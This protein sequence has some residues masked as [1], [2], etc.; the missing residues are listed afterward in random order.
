MNSPE[1]K[2]FPQ[3]LGMGLVLYNAQKMVAEGKKDEQMGSYVNMLSIKD[4]IELQIDIVS[5]C[6][7]ILNHYSISEPIKETQENAE[8][9]MGFTRNDAKAFDIFNK[10]LEKNSLSLIN[11][12]ANLAPQ[13][14]IYWMELVDIYKKQGK[15]AK[16]VEIVKKLQEMEKEQRNN[17]ATFNKITNS[18]NSMVE[19]W[20]QNKVLFQFTHD[21]DFITQMITFTSELGKWL[22]EGKCLLS[23]K[24]LTTGLQDCQICLEWISLL[25]SIAYYKIKYNFSEEN[26][27]S[28]LKD[29][30]E[31]FLGF[32]PEQL[33]PIQ[34]PNFLSLAH[35]K[36]KWMTIMGMDVITFRFMTS[37]KEAKFVHIDGDLGNDDPETHGWLSK[38]DIKIDKYGGLLIK[39]SSSEIE[40]VITH[41]ETNFG[42][43]DKIL[44]DTRQDRLH[45]DTYIMPPTKER[46]Y[47]LLITCGM[48]QRPMNAPSGMPDCQFAELFVQLPPEW[49]L[50]LEELK[51]DAQS[52]VI[53]NLY[54]FAHFVH[55][56]NTFFWHGQVI[57]LHKPLSKNAKMTGFIIAH[58]FGVPEEF[59]T[60]ELESGKKIHFLQLIPAYN[61]EMDYLEHMGWEALR[62]KFQEHA[63]SG[64]VD[65]NRENICKHVTDTIIEYKTHENQ[66]LGFKIDYPSTWM[67]NT[68]PGVPGIAFVEKKSSS[69]GQFGMLASITILPTEM[70]ESEFHNR[71]VMMAKKYNM[72]FKDFKVLRPE[73]VFKAPFPCRFLVGKG[74]RGKFYI[75]AS[76]YECLHKK[77]VYIASFLVDVNHANEKQP[78]ID[79]MMKSLRFTS[80]RTISD[81]EVDELIQDN[82][83]VF[84]NKASKID[85][86]FQRIDATS[87]RYKIDNLNGKSRI[88]DIR[89]ITV[90]FLNTSMG[91]ELLDIS[92]ISELL[93]YYLIRLKKT[94]LYEKVS[95]DEGHLG[96]IEFIKGTIE[97]L[98]DPIKDIDAISLR[99]RI[100]NLRRT[101]SMEEVLHIMEALHY[102]SLSV[103]SKEFNEFSQL[104]DLFFDNLK[105]K[106]LYKKFSGN[107]KYLEIFAQISSNFKLSHNPIKNIILSFF[108]ENEGKAFTIKALETR[109]EKS[110][111]GIVKKKDSK[112]K[113]ERILKFLVQRKIIQKDHKNNEFFYFL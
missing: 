13:Y 96:I 21:G 22:K 110:F 11:R 105:Y 66:E 85:N 6:H 95:R 87:L 60:L 80:E 78:I 90:L 89:F 70:T 55:D 52:W 67:I 79:H 39:A 32:V 47:G 33:P 102:T 113:I 28:P 63:V 101:S 108:K 23:T 81:K 112:K 43:T 75:Q 69:S 24:E 92:E 88:E 46:D 50:P 109:L 56:N 41:I 51:I 49:P 98:N 59:S 30:I 58:P 19:S 1:K 42:K 54:E 64:I 72:A 8:K 103:N 14:P 100:E 7:A 48:S 37:I 97:R 44:H 20:N 31:T 9:L 10:G 82:I 45:I 99:Q 84:K 86:H 53:E 18:Y 38:K 34:T 57:D 91:T 4:L 5:V 73:K 106:G 77:M 62:A 83:K 104:F 94:R 107:M 71:M 27:T 111:K 61:D 29:S 40:A 93:N 36:N 68:R 35:R 26:L 3:L 2:A 15:Q 76:I 65:L 12:A 16:V 74:Y 25:A 17:R